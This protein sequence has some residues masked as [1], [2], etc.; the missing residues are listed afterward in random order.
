[1]KSL[2]VRL[3]RSGKCWDSIELSD[4]SQRAKGGA[5][6]SPLTV[7]P[8]LSGAQEVLASPVVGV[9][10]QHPIALHDIYRGDVTGV[11]TLMQVWAVIH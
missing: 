4:P 6:A 9:F 5:G 7:P 8:V 1:M 2:T 11:E 10:V 3:N